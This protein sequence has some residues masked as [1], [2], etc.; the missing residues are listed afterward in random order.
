MTMAPSD[1]IQPGIAMV[2]S[3][4]MED[5]RQ[6]LLQVVK[7]NPLPPFESETILLQSNG[8]RQWL[9]LGLAETEALGISA[10]NDFLLP[11]PFIWNCYR[12][13]LPERKIAPTSIF[14]RGPLTWQIYQL[15]DATLAQDPVL[16][17]PLIRFLEESPHPIKHFQ[18]SQ[19]LAGLFDQYQ[20][21]RPDW[22]LDWS[23]PTSDLKDRLRVH[24]DQSNAL[25]MGDDQRWQPALWRALIRHLEAEN[26]HSNSRLD[27]HQDLIRAI[28]EM[29]DGARERPPALP[30]RIIVFGI[31]SLP[32][33]TLETLGHLGKIAQ[34]LFFVH[35]PCQHYWGHLI[36]GSDLLGSR[37]F[38]MNPNAQRSL[39]PE[40]LHAS[41]NALLAAWG[42]QG[43]DFIR[44]LDDWDDMAYAESLFKTDINH[45]TDTQEAATTLLS[46][47]QWGIFNLDPSPTPDEPT[48][49]VSRTDESLTFHIAHSAQRE[50]E[51]LHD[52]L[53]RLFDRKA[54]G[55]TPIAPRDVIVMLP[56]I[57]HYA[58]HIDA[59]FGRREQREG[60][61]DPP[62]IPYSIADRKNRGHNPIYKALETLLKLPQSRFTASEI[63]DLLDVEALQVRFGLTPQ[64]IPTLQH[65]IRDSG[66]R[67]GLDLAQ[68]QAGEFMPE[69]DATLKLDQ[70]T[71]SFG[72]DRLFLGYAV[73]QGDPQNGIAPYPEIGG[74]ESRLLGS[75]K[76]LIEALR[77]SA[78]ALATE[79]TPREWG[80]RFGALI[81]GYF[82]PRTP[83]DERSVGQLKDALKAWLAECG[84]ET[85]ETP[86]P[87]AVA[88]EAWTSQF[89]QPHLRQ[90]FLSGQVHFC[91]LMPMRSIPFK[92]V[93]LLGM[94]AGD[95]PRQQPPRAFDLMQQKGV[96]RP[97]D[98]SRRDD[99]RYMFLEALLSAREK[100]L[101]SWVGRSIR[102][103]SRLEASVLVNQL[104]DHV[105]N[106]WHLDDAPL[107]DREAAG[108]A[109][110]RALTTEYPLQPF[111]TRYLAPPA[112]GQKP[113]FT[114]AHRWLQIESCRSH[115]SHNSE[116]LLPWPEE[117]PPLTIQGLSRFLKDPAGHF[118]NR[119]LNVYFETDHAQTEDDECF[120]LSALDEHHLISRVLDAAA[121]DM[122][123][124]DMEQ[125]LAHL[126]LEGQLPLA[127]TGEI[128]LDTVGDTS[129]AILAREQKLR[130]GWDAPIPGSRDLTRLA[131]MID[132]GQQL[133]L[134]D[135]LK[136]LSFHSTETHRMAFFTRTASTLES[137]KEPRLDKALGLWVHHLAANAAGIPLESY[138]VGPDAAFLIPAIES[139]DRAHALLSE[140]I[141]GWREGLRAP[142]PI[143][144]AT[145]LAWLSAKT[146][147]ED[148]TARAVYEG[149]PYQM[150]DVHKSPY[151]QRAY[152]TYDDLTGERSEGHGFSA[153]SQALYAPL[154]THI[155]MIG[156]TA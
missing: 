59:V 23:D 20:V 28:N 94:N 122:P 97:G 81:E 64:D 40:D 119:R 47:V 63:L 56:D 61:D 90:R 126:R 29:A 69:G 9:K 114:Y 15:L 102:D 74:L 75:L 13:L 108:A 48:Q 144:P 42:R 147:A 124:A 123:A 91:T 115:D 57:D 58:P 35:N 87:L 89:D 106:G 36:E 146:G 80:V 133:T 148:K 65:W 27:L 88:R 84:S 21:H 104:Q 17:A 41:G 7:G 10:D 14:D 155:Q 45:F 125:C 110:L 70:N 73:G 44:L 134:E 67:W 127:A 83:G 53:L 98:R 22:L 8:I 138:L 66:I 145:A 49:P 51:I 33:Q 120:A 149:S 30:R 86:L 5:L 68:R 92:V 43:R 137:K 32:R 156:E 77:Q 153:W 107:P 62:L 96:Y 112:P 109:L 34:V 72:L 46:Q 39:S 60:E 93:C 85:F 154:K 95:Y 129:R 136:G 12:T 131:F 132:D 128:L 50:V 11:S 111:S 24:A 116:S 38:A 152:P 55:A 4:R 103:D 99:D 101:I 79:A 150:G 52:Q 117:F 16:Y 135:R 130:Q 139:A 54:D 118:F 142:L 140:I 19:Q 71:W 151:L 6:I 26:A 100:L 141:R 121:A 78:E 31:S 2:H 82:M 18:L 105:R 143:A 25:P 3:N 37:R 113:L 76:A 1:C